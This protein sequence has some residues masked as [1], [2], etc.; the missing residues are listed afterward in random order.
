MMADGATEPGV[1]SIGRAPGRM[2]FLGGVADY[3]GGFVLEMPLRQMTTVKLLATAG[4]D[5]VFAAEG[6]DPVTVKSDFWIN[7]LRQERVVEAARKAFAESGLPGW[8]IYPFGCLLL[9]AV[10]TGWEPARGL[11]FAISSEVPIGMGVSSSAALEIAT[12][13]ALRDFSGIHRTD[14]QL[15]HLGQAAE[16]Q[17]VGAPCGL[18]DQLTSSCGVPGQF[19]PISCQPDILGEAVPFPGDLALAGWASGVEHSVGGSPYGVARA[20]AFMGKKI[21]ETSEGKSWPY[22]AQIPWPAFASKI[23]DLPESLSGADFLSR[24]GGVDDALSCIEPQQNYPVRAATRFPL[25]ESQRVRQAVEGWLHLA[26][27][28]GDREARLISLGKLLHE[29]HAAYSAMGLGCEETD[30]MVAALAAEGPEKGFY[31][32]RISGGGAGGTVVVLLER[33]SLPR[34]EAI[35][36]QWEGPASAGAVFEG[37]L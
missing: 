6:K 3:S 15:A 33:Q 29:S 5:W 27:G 25:E 11:S 23:E 4:E 9:W 21:L 14:L 7:L 37:S 28:K 16:N 1:E 19:L 24:W 13:R 20:A 2:D 22:V 18:M 35:R 32:S 12:L 31:G 26:A 10:D 36:D 30:R 34:L 17:M 8:S